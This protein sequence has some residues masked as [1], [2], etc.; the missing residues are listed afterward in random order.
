MQHG[1]YLV[2]DLVGRLVVDLVVF[3][4][5]VGFAVVVSGAAEDLVVSP[6][7]IMTVTDPSSSPFLG[8]FVVSGVSVVASESH[9][10][11]PSL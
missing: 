6:V 9:V 3:V 2:V 10:S 4:G 11:W 5:F 7:F 8:S 1:K